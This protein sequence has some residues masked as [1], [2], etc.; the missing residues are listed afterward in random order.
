MDVHV[1]RT[2]IYSVGA[3]K[4][5]MT[6]MNLLTWDV[7]NVTCK[8]LLMPILLQLYYHSGSTYAMAAVGP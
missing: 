2:C 7:L 6:G 4:R 5:H 3:F 1:N 8:K